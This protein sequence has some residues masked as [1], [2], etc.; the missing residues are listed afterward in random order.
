MSDTPYDII[1]FGPSDWWGMNC[2]CTTHIM[3]RLA[4]TNKVLY[5]N[6]FSSHFQGIKK[7]L[8]KRIERKIKSLSKWLCKPAPNL[9]VFSPIFLPFQGNDII[10]GL[11]NA[12]LRMQIKGVCRYLGIKK[13]LLWMENPRAADMMNWFDACLTVYHVSDLFSDCRYISNKE[14]WRK[15]EE[16]ITRRSDVVICVSRLLYDA[17]SAIHNNVHYLPHGVDYDLFRQAAEKKLVSKHLVNIPKPIA[18]YFGTLSSSNDIELW[19]HCAQKLPQVSFVFAGLITGGDYSRL[20]AMPNVHFLGKLPYEDIPALCAGFD[21]CMLQWRMTDWIRH[22]NP[23]KFMEYMA[24]GNPVVSVPIDEIK[25]KYCGLVSIAET[26]EQYCEAIAWELGNDTDA[27][28][29]DRINIAAE[30]SWASH[31]D[32]VCA[33]IDTVPNMSGS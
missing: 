18:G 33:I 13:P 19:E 17:K 29:Q 26:K 15:R 30:H 25:D 28:A 14:Q 2:S 9:H 22:C 6:P 7:G 31:V 1:C 3:Q 4:L 21:V 27:R 20:E 24:S 5:I 16:E 23:L 12:F 32:K 8:S 11:N 10:D